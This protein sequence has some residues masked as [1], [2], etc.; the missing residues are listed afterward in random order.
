MSGQARDFG[1]SSGSQADVEPA[2]EVL[3]DA[4]DTAPTL[5]GRPMAAK[6]G[7]GILQG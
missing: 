1:V 3:R 7:H 4:I 6:I 2:S 5:P